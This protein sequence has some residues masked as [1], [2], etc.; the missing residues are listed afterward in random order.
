MQNDLK[1]IREL[2]GEVDQLDAVLR[3]AMPVAFA[4]D[5][6]TFF[7]GG[8]AKVLSDSSGKLCLIFDQ[9]MKAAKLAEDEFQKQETTVAQGGP[10]PMDFA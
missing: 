7:A 1:K 5:D 8:V 4:I 10:C 3:D 6:R 9:I 2:A